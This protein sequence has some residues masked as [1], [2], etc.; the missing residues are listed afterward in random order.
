[1]VDIFRSIFN[2]S[3][4]YLKITGREH[5]L[6]LMRLSDAEYEEYFSKHPARLLGG[7]K[8]MAPA[9]VG[10]QLGR[11]API[12][13]V[14]EINVPIFFIGAEY[15]GLCPI[16]EIKKAGEL[17]KSSDIYIRDCHHFQ[18]YRG[19]H[20]NAIIDATNAFLKKIL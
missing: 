3:P 9:R 5:E 12:K 17:A 10:L 19:E 11:Y 14:N 15:D 4:V 7:W 2:L 6:A 20:F 13:R 16:S 1:L 8:N 18:I